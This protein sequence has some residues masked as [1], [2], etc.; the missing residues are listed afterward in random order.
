MYGQG[1]HAGRERQQRKDTFFGEFGLSYLEQ[2][3]PRARDPLQVRPHVVEPGSR[4][5]C[6]ARVLVLVNELEP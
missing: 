3:E 6:T 1:L 5:P 2:R 4:A